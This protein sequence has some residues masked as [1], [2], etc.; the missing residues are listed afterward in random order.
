MFLRSKEIERKNV[1]RSLQ[2][3]WLSE[4]QID[5][6]IGGITFWLK[7]SIYTQAKQGLTD[8][9]RA[10]IGDLGLELFPVE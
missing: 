8:K 3:V 10:Q 5:K 4:R 2:K 6:E 9:Q 7:E 1:I